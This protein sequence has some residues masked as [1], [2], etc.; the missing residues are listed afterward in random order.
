[1][2]CGAFPTLF[3]VASR[4]PAQNLRGDFAEPRPDR[5]NGMPTTKDMSG[6]VCMRDRA[7]T[8]QI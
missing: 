4:F 2:G 7:A 8:Y 1:M 6:G 5:P 3:L